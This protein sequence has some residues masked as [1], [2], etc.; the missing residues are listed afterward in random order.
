[1]LL[2]GFYFSFAHT[3]GRLVEQDNYK[4]PI[5]MDY[6]KRWRLENNATQLIVLC[7]AVHVLLGAHTDGT[8]LALMR[9]AAWVFFASTI[10]VLGRK[11]DGPED[12]P[13]AVLP[14]CRMER[15]QWHRRWLR[16]RMSG[17]RLWLLLMGSLQVYALASGIFYWISAVA[18]E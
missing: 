17:A 3:W 10:Y 9:V 18:A 5:F 4:A 14:E 8:I 6:V 2:L 11:V 1:M 13:E 12:V 16:K 7:S 15:I